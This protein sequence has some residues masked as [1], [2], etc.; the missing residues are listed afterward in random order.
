MH[1]PQMSEL[2][3]WLQDFLQRAVSRRWLSEHY[4]CRPAQ[5]STIKLHCKSSAPSKRMPL[6]PSTACWTVTA[7][8]KT[9]LQEGARALINSLSRPL[10]QLRD[11]DVRSAKGPACLACL[12]QQSAETAHQR[13]NES[14]KTGWPYVLSLSPI[15]SSLVSTELTAPRLA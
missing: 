6:P 10:S 3:K 1:L 7:G 9:V 12:K 8:S 14:D 15:R 2:D 11:A 13:P 4:C 5:Q